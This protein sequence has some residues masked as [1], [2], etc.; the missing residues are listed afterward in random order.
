MFWTRQ[1]ISNCAREPMTRLGMLFP[2]SADFNLQPCC[3]PNGIRRDD[4]LSTVTPKVAALLP[5]Q[6]LTGVNSDSVSLSIFET[7]APLSSLSEV[8]IKLAATASSVRADDSDG[9]DSSPRTR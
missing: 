9:P 7:P 4:P 5:T 1:A 8:S 6:S 2:V 3:T